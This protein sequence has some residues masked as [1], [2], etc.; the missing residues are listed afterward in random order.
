MRPK[1]ALVVCYKDTYGTESAVKKALKKEKI[2]HK[3]IN[4]DMLTKESFQKADLV[5]S[6]GGDGTFLTASQYIK[7]QPVLVVA[8]NFKKNEGFFAAAGK[9]EFHKKLKMIINDEFTTIK[10]NRLQPLIVKG[11]KRMNIPPAINEVYIGCKRPYI[12]ARYVLKIGN[13]K[14]FQ[15]SSGVIVST[16]A[17]S[18]AWIKSA[19]G[20]KLPLS[21]K[22]TQYL[23]REPYFGRLTKPKMRKGVLPENAAVKI[24]SLM[25][26]G[27]AVVDSRHTEYELDEGSSIIIRNAK[28]PLNLITF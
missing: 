28:K 3:C 27:I 2:N 7:D 20:R 23:I 15:K 26:D 12:T 22:K 4:R 11:K 21:T 19:G 13:K 8:S 1:F 25:W 10:L 16:A 6:V 14:E 17:G 5:I 9:K 18:N 24:K